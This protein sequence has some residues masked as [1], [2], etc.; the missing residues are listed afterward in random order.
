ML[1]PYN[2]DG[3]YYYLYSKLKPDLKK[4]YEKIYSGLIDTRKSIIIDG[5]YNADLVF[6]IKDFVIRDHPEIFWDGGGS[7]VWSGS[8][9]YVNKMDLRYKFQ[10]NE[11]LKKKKELNNAISHFVEG[12]EG[13]T[14][15]EKERL[16]HDRLAEELEYEFND[17]DQTSYGSLV[18]KRAVCAGYSRG[19]Q[20]LMRIVG[21]PCFYLSGLAQG[22]EDKS[23]ERHGWNIVEINGQYYNV[24]LTW[25]HVIISDKGKKIYHHHY[26]NCD[27]DD[28]AKNHKRDDLS[29]YLPGCSGQQYTFENLYGINPIV[30]EI[31]QDGLTHTTVVRNKK[32]FKE[33]FA[34]ELQ[35]SDGK[36]I[37][38]VAFI[39]DS[40]DI[41]DLCMKWIGD[42]A[43]KEKKF[44]GFEVR[45]RVRDYGKGLYR[46]M[47]GVKFD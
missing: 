20:L 7:S 16:I 37:V 47:I 21:M 41:V 43:R 33:I 39:I 17:L 45:S 22:S 6:T 40:K 1:T 26:Y 8:D 28:I 38:A 23:W 11:L 29:R 10:G 13:K 25:D 12:L 14:L 36:E 19:F 3:K 5:K 34:S 2:F 4:L 35:K 46:L 31:Y 32:D 30:D 9:G 15:L 27:D 24:D 44:G 18:N 42:L